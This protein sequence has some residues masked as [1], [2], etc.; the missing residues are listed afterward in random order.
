MPVLPA[1]FRLNTVFL[2]FLI[3]FSVPPAPFLAPFLRFVFQLRVASFFPHQRPKFVDS[4]TG[5]CAISC[6]VLMVVRNKPHAPPLLLQVRVFFPIT[7]LLSVG[8][9][10]EYHLSPISHRSRCRPSFSSPPLSWFF[11]PHPG[12]HFARALTPPFCRFFEPE[13]SKKSTFRFFNIEDFHP[14]ARIGVSL[15]KKFSLR[16]SPTFSPFFFFPPSPSAPGP[17]TPST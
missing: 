8:C 9:F 12:M 11:P 4:L 16:F 7:L 3:A 1:S 14:P 13:P 17:C 5:F 15:P 2:L 6:S 10:R